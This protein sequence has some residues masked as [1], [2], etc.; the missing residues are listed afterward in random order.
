MKNRILLTAFLLCTLANISIAQNL[1]SGKGFDEIH[2][3][4][5]RSDA[6]ILLGQATSVSDYESEKNS[7]KESGIDVEKELVFII[8]F[9]NVCTYA[10]NKYCIWKIF[11]KNNRAVYF[12]MSGYLSDKDYT[13]NITVNNSLL[14]DDSIDKATELFGKSPVKIKD[15]DSAYYYYFPAS[16]IS[17]YV[18]EEKIKVFYIFEAY[19]G[20]ELKKIL[21]LIK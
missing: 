17:L 13:K 21:K 14:F 8:G 18:E 3:G 1:I 19:K 2:L 12:I 15:D 11:Y 6:E 9:D 10:D 16:G 5:L 20:K 7:W 4:T